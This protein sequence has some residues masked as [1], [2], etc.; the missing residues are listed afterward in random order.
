MIERFI[1]HLGLKEKFFMAFFAAIVLT[2]GISG[3]VIFDNERNA[4]QESLRD[5]GLSLAS[6]LAEISKDNILNQ[7]DVEL[8]NSV[9]G[10]NNDPDVAYTFI[11]DL[12]G[13]LLTGLLPSV[14]LQNDLIKRAFDVMPKD[15]PLA[16]SLALIRKTKGILE[17]SKVVAVDSENVGIVTIGLSTYRINAVIRNSMHII[18][19]GVILGFFCAFGLA[20]IGQKVLIEPL[21]AMAQKMKFVS[22]RHDYAVR[23]RSSSRDE[24]GELAKAFDEMLD[25][26]QLRDSKLESSQQRLLQSEKL[27]AIGQLGAGVAHELNQPLMGISMYL[28][29]L[30]KKEA[31]KSDPD[32]LQIITKIKDQIMRMGGV[33]NNLRSFA[34][35]NKPRYQS[36]SINKPLLDGY[37]LLRQQMVDHGVDTAVK[38]Q[39][40]LP[41]VVGNSN[42]LQQVFINIIANAKDVVLE[43]APE[44]ERRV[45]VESRAACGGRLIEVRIEDSGKGMD[46]ATRSRIFEAFFTTKPAG[47]GTGLGLSIAHEI[48]MAHHG[49]IGVISQPGKG[50]VF[51]VFLPVEGSN[52]NFEN[53]DF[54]PECAYNKDSLTCE[55]VETIKS[56][57]QSVKSVTKG[58]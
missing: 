51:S 10:I 33:V 12:K 54:C 56:S 7:N 28:E 35:E 49:Y 2:G 37:S 11:Y 44:Q 45:F 36:I 57:S 6:Y 27:A 19:F 18:I 38:L 52:L 22:E 8:N 13:D 31:V 1:A 4:F 32:A 15:L 40:D 30:K 9:D 29:S 53:R 26:V 14:N 47:K 5:K 3:W 21:L 46:E 41:K 42:Q 23:I 24:I 20:F 48:I 34:R 50:S 58:S 43:G 17:L 55:V 16:K 25:Q 39:E